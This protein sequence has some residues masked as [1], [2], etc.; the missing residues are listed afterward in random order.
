[1]SKAGV[2]PVRLRCTGESD[3]AGT[4]TLDS[5]A[6]SAAAKKKK[7]AK[8]VRLGRKSFAIVASKSATVKVKLNRKAR[9]AVARKRRLRA[10]AVV[11]I[12]GAK[13]TRSLAIAGAQALIWQAAGEPAAADKR[14][15]VKP[16][17]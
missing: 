17:V 15:G 16:A 12:A 7:K 5:T 6:V 13:T 10:R 3:C 4:L 14:N 9:R 1:M 8:R 2:V 11:S